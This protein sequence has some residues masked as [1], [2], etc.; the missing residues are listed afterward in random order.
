MSSEYYQDDDDDDYNITF[1]APTTTSTSTKPSSSSTIQPPPP[2]QSLSSPSAPT[3]ATTPSRDQLQSSQSILQ[4]QQHHQPQGEV[5]T[6]PDEDESLYS[7][8]LN[9]S[10]QDKPWK[11]PGAD[12]T[13]YFNYG[14]TEESWN[15]YCTRQLEIKRAT[16]QNK[17][18]PIRPFN[19]TSHQTNT[20]QPNGLL[21]I[22]SNTT[23]TTTTTAHTRPSLIQPPIPS[24]QSQP[25]GLAPPPPPPIIGNN[26]NARERNRDYQ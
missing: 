22:N 17:P 19:T 7:L 3:T 24:V 16:R 4:H 13:D 23:T 21:P 26:N 12:I 1:T 6:L 20:T 10:F 5:S 25:F 18:I 8:D 14:F 9:S 15:V 2:P 11:R